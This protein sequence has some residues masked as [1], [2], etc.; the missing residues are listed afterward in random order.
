MFH[1]ML[2]R[3]LAMGPILLHVVVVWIMNNVMYVDIHLSVGC[4]LF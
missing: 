4:S 2:A 1:V 3:Y